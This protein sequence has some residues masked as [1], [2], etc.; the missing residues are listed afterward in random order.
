MNIW[1]HFFDLDKDS[2]NKEATLL[3]PAAD[4][5]AGVPRLRRALPQ[6]SAARCQGPARPGVRRIRAGEKK[7]RYERSGNCSDVSCEACFKQAR[8]SETGNIK[9]KDQTLRGPPAQRPRQTPDQN[10][11]GASQAQRP[12]VMVPR[13]EGRA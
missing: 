11:R 3:T 12:A 7:C 10:H 13:D 8:A 1:G 4:Q 6:H 5:P 9:S 2:N